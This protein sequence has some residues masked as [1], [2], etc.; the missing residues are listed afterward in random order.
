[1]IRLT[2]DDLT[3]TDSQALKIRYHLLEF[4]PA[5][6]CTI[7]RGPGPV[8]EV[9]DHDPA[10]LAPGVLDRIEQIANCS[11]KVESAPDKPLP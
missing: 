9:P 3:L 4:I 10:E 6:R 1:M 11:F 7:H 2:A 8:I 5:T